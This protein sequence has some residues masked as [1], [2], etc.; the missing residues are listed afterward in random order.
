MVSWAIAFIVAAIVVGVFGVV[1]AGP[2]GLLFVAFFLGL[3]VWALVRHHRRE[4]NRDG[5]L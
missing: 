3:A 4:G 2:A 5:G 1:A